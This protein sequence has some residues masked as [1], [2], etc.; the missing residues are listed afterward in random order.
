M[1][2]LI[3][4]VKTSI[5]QYLACRSYRAKLPYQLKVLYGQSHHY[6]PTQISVAIRKA[7]L[8]LKHRQSAYEMFMTQEQIRSFQEKNLL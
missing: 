1:F 3:S 8:S 7:G 5:A 6:S 2:R 4:Q